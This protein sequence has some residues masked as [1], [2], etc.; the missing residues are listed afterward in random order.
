MENLN[1]ADG[2]STDSVDTTAMTLSLPDLWSL[3]LC[4]HRVSLLLWICQDNPMLLTPRCE[5][6]IETFL[7]QI[8]SLVACLSGKI[9]LCNRTLGTITKA[10]SP[11][12]SCMIAAIIAYA[13][14]GLIRRVSIASG[15]RLGG[16]SLDI[17]RRKFSRE[18][19]KSIW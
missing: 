12:P 7:P 1:F 6:V 18:G 11:M 8:D 4:L 15:D 3:R 9:K 5:L 2:G 13:C 17:R 10:K 14:D 16:L 19:Q